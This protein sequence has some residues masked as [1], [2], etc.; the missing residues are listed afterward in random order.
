MHEMMVSIIYL[1]RDIMLMGTMMPRE[2]CMSVTAVFGMGVTGATK[3]GLNV[4]KD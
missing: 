3:T 2:P 4:I 1:E